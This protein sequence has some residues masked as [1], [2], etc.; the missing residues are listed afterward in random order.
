[1]CRFFLLALGTTPKRTIKST[2]K[3]SALICHGFA[4]DASNTR[5]E[6]VSAAEWQIEP[7]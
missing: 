5:A 2:L 1:M 6:D 4:V 7:T 3:S